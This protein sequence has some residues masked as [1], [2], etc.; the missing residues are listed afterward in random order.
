[1]APAGLWWG[2]GVRVSRSPAKGLARPSAS[3]V[4]AARS[5]PGA[6]EQLTW[7]ATV[8]GWHYVQARLDAKNGPVPTVLSLARK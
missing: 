6:R 3:S 4:R 2:L 8:T 5:A 7:T 1:M